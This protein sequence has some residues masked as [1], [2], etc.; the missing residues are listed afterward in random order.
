MSF[1]DTP[2][3]V[4]PTVAANP[5][6]KKAGRPLGA[7]NKKPAAKKTTNDAGLNKLSAAL[8]HAE[9]HIKHIEGEYKKLGQRYTHDVNKLHSIIGYLETNLKEAWQTDA[10]NDASSI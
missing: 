5:V 3:Q 9:L 6:K 4:E 1:E 2:T 7:K 8:R 10:L